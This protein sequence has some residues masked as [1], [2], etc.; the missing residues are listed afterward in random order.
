MKYQGKLFVSVKFLKENSL[1]SNESVFFKTIPQR[2]KLKVLDNKLYDE[3][4]TIKGKLESINE[5]DME[6]PGWVVP[7]SDIEVD[8]EPVPAL[9]DIKPDTVFDYLDFI[10]YDFYQSMKWVGYAKRT[11]LGGNE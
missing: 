8:V 11:K 6:L 10:S 5:V 1:I 9:H 3:V 2:Y 4:E 7:L